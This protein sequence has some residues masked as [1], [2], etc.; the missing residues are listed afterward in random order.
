MRSVGPQ[1]WMDV[2]REKGLVR[3][4]APAVRWEPNPLLTTEHFLLLLPQ[5]QVA[6]PVFQKVVLRRWG[7]KRGLLF[8]VGHFL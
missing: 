8:L 6:L 1:L 7:P 2:G 5:G 4:T 3:L